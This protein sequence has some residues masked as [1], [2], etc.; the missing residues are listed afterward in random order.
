[1]GVISDLIP[2]VDEILGIRDDLGVALKEVW[3][4]TRT[5]SGSEIGVGTFTE[6]RVRMLPSPRVVEFSQDLRIKEGGSVRAGD[7]QLKMVSKESYSTEAS[8]DCS[9]NTANVEKFYE[10][11]GIVYRPISITEKHLTWTILLRRVSDQSRS[12]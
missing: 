4:V 9:S 10:V 11:G 1:M 2:S 8:V 3:M 12:L 6:V 7:I 5:W